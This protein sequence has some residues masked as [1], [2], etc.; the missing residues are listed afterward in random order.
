[1]TGR[2]VAIGDSF[3]EGVGDPNLLYPNGVRGWADR[4]A[5]QMGRADERWQY[6]NFAIRSKR[7]DEIIDEQFDDALAL[8]PT[9]IT[10]Y[11]GGN[12]ILAVRAD[13]PAIM[14]K[15]EAAVRRLT[16]THADIVLFTTFD[17]KISTA[18]EPLRRRI[19]YYN[20]IVREIGK[21]HGALVVDHTQYNEFH[22]PRMWAFD[23]IHMSKVGHKHMAAAVLA[24][25]GIPH[26]LKL[27][28]LPPFE[29][30]AWRDAVRTEATWL[31]TEVVPLLRRRMNGVREGDTLPPK[32]PDL[33]YPAEGM[34]RQARDRS[35]DAK[36]VRQRQ[37]GRHH[38]KDARRSA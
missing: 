14:E 26:T 5:R 16:E 25:L 3:S 38:A 4:M 2:Y 11:A 6:A 35:G 23:R 18:L 20:N 12:D 28:E 37:R 34:K 32:W 24:Q 27:P 31:R 10:F 1:M 21:S 30:P 22:D 29:S 17:P 13:M 19:V 7:L 8:D 33:I 9:L 15:Y 36:E